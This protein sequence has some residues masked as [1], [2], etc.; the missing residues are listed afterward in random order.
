MVNVVAVVNERYQSEELLLRSRAGIPTKEIL[1]AATINCAEL[2]M[3]QVQALACE[4]THT[5]DIGMHTRCAQV[6]C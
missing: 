1:A 6:R 3:K 2:F 5:V 4:L